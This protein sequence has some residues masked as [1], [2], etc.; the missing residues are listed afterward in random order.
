[1]DFSK[2]QYKCS[3]LDMEFNLADK[4]LYNELYN[5]YIKCNRN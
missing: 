5:K 3:Y 1:M 4:N 2:F